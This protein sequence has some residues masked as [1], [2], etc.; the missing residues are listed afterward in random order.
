MQIKELNKSDNLSIINLWNESIDDSF[1]YKRLNEEIYE[2]YFFRN[3]D[4]YEIVS[5]KALVD[6]KI[7]GFS[8]GVLYPSRNTF[9]LTMI[10]V[11]KDYRLKGI[12]KKLYEA[13]EEVFI[14]I[15]AINKVE[16][17]FRNPINLIWNVPNTL[18]HEHPNA[19]GVDLKGDGYLFL[20]NLGFRDFAY[21]NSYYKRI[22]DYEYSDSVKARLLKL[23]EENMTTDFYQIDKHF[24]LEDLMKDLNSEAWEKEILDHVALK[25]KDNTLLVALDGDL[26]I[27]FT[28]PIHRQESGRG[29][30]AGIGI[31][32]A[33]RGK[34]VGTLLFSRLCMGFKEIGVDYVT[35]FTGKNNPARNIYEREDFKI[36]RSWANMRK[37]IKKWKK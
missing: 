19:P 29:Y 10:L 24:G 7:V 33:Y 2:S 12:G 25:G 14:K 8:S 23:K 34:G 21:Q 17:F 26:V 18:N 1:I 32:S 20:K 36:V 37:E 22:Y 16:A 28:G 35:L 5:F 13:L 27:G 30:F 15:E 9:Y 6:N 11:E 4:E 3:N 31:H